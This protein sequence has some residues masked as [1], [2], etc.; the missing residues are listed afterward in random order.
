MGKTAREIGVILDR[1]TDLVPSVCSGSDGET[2]VDLR[3]SA[4]MCW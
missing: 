2:Q 4:L 3:A 1:S